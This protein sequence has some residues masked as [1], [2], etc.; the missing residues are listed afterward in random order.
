MLRRGA[1]PGQP[2]PRR[3][4]YSPRARR[5]GCL[6]GDPLPRRAWRGRPRRRRS[7]PL[8][9]LRRPEPTA[10]AAGACGGRPSAT[11]PLRRARVRPPSGAGARC[12]CGPTSGDCG[13]GGP[14]IRW[15]C[16]SGAGVCCYGESISDAGEPV[17]CGSGSSTAGPMGPGGGGLGPVPSCRVRR[18]GLWRRLRCAGD[19][20]EYLASYG[21]LGRTGAPA[22]TRNAP[23]FNGAAAAVR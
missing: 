9:P 21:A 8:D 11:D 12:G 6:R 19:Y 15:G 2:E 14:R 20:L 13:G 7:S 23:I 18:G 1:L 5:M 3:S 10:A 4:A 16:R 17:R 22:P